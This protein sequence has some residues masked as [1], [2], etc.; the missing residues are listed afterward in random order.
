MPEG[1]KTDCEVKLRIKRHRQRITADEFQSGI[2]RGAGGEL[3][4]HGQHPQAE[5]KPDQTPAAQNSHGTH[6]S[7]CSAADIETGI[8]WPNRPNVV[9]HGFQDD[10]RRAKGRVIELWREQV[11]TSFRGGKSL[12]GEL[13]E[14]RPLRM[15]HQ[16]C[17][18]WL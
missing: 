17:R 16:R 4:G 1:A 14:S 11:V 13:P 7:A 9:G 18:S 6:G 10:V 15:K 12:N 5:I 3:P 8:E 2:S